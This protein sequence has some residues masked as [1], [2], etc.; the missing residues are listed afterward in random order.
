MAKAPSLKDQL[1]AAATHQ[2][3]TYHAAPQSLVDA[4]GT[5][6]LFSILRNIVES[7]VAAGRDQV[8]TPEFIDA[9]E[10][11]LDD[12]WADF[13][14]PVNWPIPDLIEPKVEGMSLALAKRLVRAALTSKAAA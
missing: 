8:A 13:V 11:A 1:V 14:I 10:A 5:A 7:I 12:L 6:G 9:A 3:Q 4:G 2:L